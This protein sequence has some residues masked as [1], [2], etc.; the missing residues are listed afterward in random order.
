[1]RLL[2]Q[3]NYQR[4]MLREIASDEDIRAFAVVSSLAIFIFSLS[5]FLTMSLGDLISG[6]LF[7]GIH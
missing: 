5:F 2:N 4:N 1:M 7:Y 3:E 6:W